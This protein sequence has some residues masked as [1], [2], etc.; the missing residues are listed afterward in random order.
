MTQPTLPWQPGDLVLA[1]DGHLWVRAYPEDVEK[2]W[3]WAHSAETVG[4]GSGAVEEDY[5]VR[6]LTLLVRDG[7]AV[8]GTVVAE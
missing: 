7:R 4:A 5:P 6:P 2:G 1:A 3:P 8:G